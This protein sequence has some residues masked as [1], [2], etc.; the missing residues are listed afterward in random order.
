MSPFDEE[1]PILRNNNGRGDAKC[2]ST[3]ARNNKVSFSAVVGSM[4]ADGND[5]EASMPSPNVPSSCCGAATILQTFLKSIPAA[6]LMCALNLMLA[7]PFGSAYFS[8][9]IPLDETT[10]EALGIRLSLMALCVGQFVMGGGLGSLGSSAFDPVM[11]WQLGEL[12]PFYHT[13][14]NVAA[15][16]SDSDDEILPTTLY[17][18]SL[19]SVCVGLI[20]YALGKLGFGQL[21]YFFPTHVL[22][23]L[24]GGIGAWLAVLSTSISISPSRA[25]AGPEVFSA[26]TVQFLVSFGFA[27]GLRFLRM[28]FPKEKFM[29]LDPI[30]FLSIPVVF[31]LV[32]FAFGISLDDAIAA[33]FFFADPEG[34]ADDAATS[35]WVETGRLWTEFDFAKVHYNSIFYAAPTILSAGLMGVMIGSPFIPATASLFK[36]IDFDFNREF[37]SLGWVNVLS[38]LV[39]PGG[40]GVAVCYSTTSVYKSCGGRGKLANAFLSLITALTMV[41][42]P[43]AVLYIPRCLAGSIVLDLGINLFLE[44]VVD[45]A[46]QCDYAEYISIWIIIVVL[47]VFNM[48]AALLAGLL[49][50]VVT[51]ALQT[52]V[53]K[54]PVRLVC[55]AT[56]FPSSRYRNNT[57]QKI[58]DDPAKGRSRIV[59]IQ[60]QGHLFFGNVAAIQERIMEILDEKMQQ[61]GD[62]YRVLIDFTLVLG[63]DTTASQYFE[64]MVEKI[65][66][67]YDA[68]TYYISGPLEPK[69]SRASPATTSSASSRRRKSSVVFSQTPPSQ[70]FAASRRTTHSSKSRRI[71]CSVRGHYEQL[72]QQAVIHGTFFETLDEALIQAED[73]IIALQSLAS[74][75]DLPVF[76]LA[77]RDEEKMEI[78]E[79][80]SDKM[81]GATQEAIGDLVSFCTREIRSRGD[82]LWMAGDEGTSAKIFV[83]GTLVAITDGSSGKQ[84]RTAIETGE[85]VGL[86][87]MILSERHSATLICE[88]ECVFY[89][90]DTESYARLVE[91]KPAVAR[92]CLDVYLARDLSRRLKHAS[93]KLYL[94]SSATAF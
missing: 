35:P 29:L 43:A 21:T 50:A 81:I 52:S 42:G 74:L 70:A 88:S 56:E 92:V 31:Y 84:K 57:S 19:S 90:L 55:D 23:G 71:S 36:G 30:F 78:I 62:V 11:V 69:G 5:E 40:L 68:A 20:A 22:L 26:F 12:S 38:G 64:R 28:I 79:H 25:P 48:T 16:M 1:T 75:L 46:E 45:P 89:S 73:E 17:L 85:I 77:E 54:D 58:L 91:E 8:P 61:G 32:M 94:S 24:V 63:I 59:I 2:E 93:N 47:N 14:A 27:M 37:V 53:D 49:A 13:L 83:G 39:C 9:V 3:N 72:D 33:G 44:A 65:Q 34:A 80:L 18:L 15:A 7:V 76:D 6:F 4:V 41:Y 66:K 87:S 60:L 51:Y 86:R 67:Q 82:S 10:R